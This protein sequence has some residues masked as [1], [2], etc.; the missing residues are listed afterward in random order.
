MSNEKKILKYLGF[1]KTEFGMSYAF[2]SFSNYR[3][4]AGPIETYSFYNDNGCITFHHIIQRGEWGWYTSKEFSNIQEGLLEKE[5]E[6]REYLHKSYFLTKS[7]LKDLQQ[8]L[9]EEIKQ[10]GTVFHIKV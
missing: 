3:G 7:W 1:L 6:Q 8:A 9:H 4:F 10:Y 2:Q 5:I